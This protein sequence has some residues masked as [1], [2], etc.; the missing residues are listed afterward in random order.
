MRL[1]PAHAQTPQLRYTVSAQ[2]CI[3]PG[4]TNLAAAAH[5]GGSPHAFGMTQF[6]GL[7]LAAEVK[8]D[9]NWLR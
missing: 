8:A 3:A 7:Q 6:L 5:P 1:P 9:A 4:V 2:S